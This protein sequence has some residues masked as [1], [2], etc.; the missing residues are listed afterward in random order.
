MST[1]PASDPALMIP[2]W[3][4]PDPRRRRC[5]ARVYLEDLYVKPEARGHGVG[6]VRD[7][8][9]SLCEDRQ[10]GS[11]KRAVCVSRR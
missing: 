7:T 4:V 8:V 9:L 10:L 1:P 6:T 5:E 11:G 2:L 3:I